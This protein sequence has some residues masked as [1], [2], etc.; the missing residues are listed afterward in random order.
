MKLSSFDYYLPE[1][2][3]AKYPCQKRDESNLLILKSKTGLITTTKFKN[4][5]NYLSKDDL[6]VANDVKVIPAR[7][8]GNRESGGKVELLLTEKE[9]QF[10][11]KALIRSSKRLKITNKI[12]FKDF[13]CDILD[14]KEQ[15]FTVKFSRELDYHDLFNID[16]HMPIPPYLKRGDEEIDKSAYQTIYSNDLKL[17]AI[18]APTAG[19]HFTKDTFDTIKGKGVEI[20]FV[21][22]YI[23]IGTF[24]PVREED[25]NKHKIHKEFYEISEKTEKIINSAIKS[26]K[27]IIAVGTTSTRALEDN[28]KKFGCIRAGRFEADIFIYP[29]KTFNVINKLV[30]NFHLPKSTLLMLVSAFG[31]IDNIRNCYNLAITKKFRFFSYGDAMFIE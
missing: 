12:F 27:N 26:G 2:L 5:V 16:S 15:L 24:N 6:I 28:F 3:I 30:T 13:T 25:I 7:I 1:Y 23:G 8:F 18:A 11:W 14:F 31:G 19:L 22:L 29:G 20:C 9:D 17:G 21:T 10:K 4:I